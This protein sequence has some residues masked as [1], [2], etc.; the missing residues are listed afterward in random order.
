MAWRML[1][2]W[3]TMRRLCLIAALAL[4]PALSADDA[5]DLRASFEA[6]VAA[7]NQGDVE[8]FLADIHPEAMSFYS[9]GP[10]SGKQGK[11]ACQLDWERFFGKTNEARFEPQNMQF[12]V[13]GNTGMAWGDYDVQVD[14]QGKQVNHKGRY[15]FT[16]TK[17]DGK[18]MVVMQHNTPAAMDPQPVRKRKP[19]SE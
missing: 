4:T 9:C 6:G 3:A 2:S 13:V 8:G 12:K 19:A 11:E 17:V 10:T 14:Y 15:T 18:W 16:Y 5:A 7:L 1:Q